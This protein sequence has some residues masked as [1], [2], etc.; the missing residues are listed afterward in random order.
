MNP[1]LS[2]RTAVLTAVLGVG[3]VLD[4]D[5]SVGESAVALGAQ[6]PAHVDTALHWIKSVQPVNN[7]Y[8]DPA[9][10]QST[11]G[12]LYAT[13]KCG[14]FV[15]QL[16]LQT[17]SGVITPSVLMDLTGSTSPDA[18]QWY[19]A[20]DPAVT[21]WRSP[22]SGIS[23]IPVDA[24]LAGPTG[25][26]LRSGTITTLRTGDILA[27]RYALGSVTGHAM[28]VA[29]ISAPPSDQKLLLVGQKAIPGISYVKRW[30]IRV[31]DSTTS[32]HDSSSTSTDT[33]YQR[34]PLEA[35]HHDHGIGAGDIFLYEDSSAASPTFGR[36]VGW[37]WSTS[38]SSTFQF[39]DPNAVDANGK[40]TYRPMVV[41]RLSG[42]PL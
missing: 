6:W 12:V 31:V 41:G 21:H 23:V 1:W 19:A 29:A 8:G 22:S 2:L 28:V 17:Y 15:N 13:S 35:D 3:C 39:S 20:I 32:V 24:S 34:D 18:S 37:S 11:S 30:T 25:R 33:R 40:S 14:S 9:S 27:A 10:I 5:D 38:S 26:K 4:S 16:L 36:L 7:H 42:T